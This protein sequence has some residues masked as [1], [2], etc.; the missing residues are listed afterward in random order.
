M[1][2]LVLVLFLIFSP[3]LIRADSITIVGTNGWAEAYNPR[4][5][6]ESTTSTGGFIEFEA[7][8]PTHGSLPGN[9]A[10]ST[11]WLYA[12]SGTVEFD[13]GLSH[14]FYNASKQTLT[15]QFQG[16]EYNFAGTV[17]EP[18]S[19]GLLGTGLLMIGRIARR[20]L[21]AALG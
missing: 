15:G 12:Y 18:G 11:G 16:W 1:K 7:Y 20:R 10:Y 19:L 4:F 5:Y 3:A 17:S 6:G 13:G 9:T 2:N 14:I 8:Q 21:T